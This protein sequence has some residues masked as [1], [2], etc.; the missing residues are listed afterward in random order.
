[1][2]KKLM[3]FK[4]KRTPKEALGFYLAYLLLIVVVGGL[5]GGILGLLIGEGSIE[6]G[7][8]MGGIV[9]VIISLSLSFMILSKK[10]LT[11]NF[12]MILLALLSGIL[13]FIGGGLLGL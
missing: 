7:M 11:N 1:M 5:I 13:S 3:D 8:R 4:Y 2:F 10:K 6:L 12:G 9:A